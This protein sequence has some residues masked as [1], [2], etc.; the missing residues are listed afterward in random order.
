MHPR[1]PSSEAPPCLPVPVRAA[2]WPPTGPGRLPRWPLLP[3]HLAGPAEG[4]RRLC[5]GALRPDSSC[6]WALRP[7]PCPHTRVWH[8]ANLAQQRGPGSC[9]ALAGV[10]RLGAGP[11]PWDR[12]SPP[13][14]SPSGVGARP[15][16]GR[17]WEQG[18]GAAWLVA[19]PVWSCPRGGPRRVPGAVRSRRR[20]GVIPARGPRC[21]FG[22]GQGCAL[23]RA[24][25]SA[26]ASCRRSLRTEPRAARGAAVA[27][28]AHSGH[29]APLLQSRGDGVLPQARAEPAVRAHGAGPRVGAPRVWVVPPRQRAPARASPLCTAAPTPRRAEAWRS[30]E[31]RRSWGSPGLCLCHARG[32]GAF[33]SQHALR[34]RRRAP[35]GRGLR[36]PLLPPVPGLSPRECWAW[37]RAPAAGDAPRPV[38]ARPLPVSDSVAWRWG[39]S[40][41]ALAPSLPCAP[42]PRASL[43]RGSPR[44]DRR[45]LFPSLPQGHHLARRR[46]QGR[47]DG[48]AAVRLRGR[49]PH[50]ARPLPGRH[51]RAALHGVQR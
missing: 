49:G 46:G 11:Q 13:P 20:A 34:G 38:R 40:H 18:A 6:R 24:R 28:L 44:A 39:S 45:P 30:L 37:R 23:R 3:C 8:T 50:Q 41:P 5:P 32:A 48:P 15:G 2:A 51:G 16:P 12:A 35:R 25:S 33:T 47:A 27:V 29:A 9:L 19:G 14:A 43:G 7:Q 17:G 10:T 26:R 4:D 36:P 31:S 1:G 21:P 22:K 42:S